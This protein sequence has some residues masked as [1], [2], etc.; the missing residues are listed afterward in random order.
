M[1][2]AVYEVPNGATAYGRAANGATP[3]LATVATATRATNTNVCN[4]TMGDNIRMCSQ[5]VGCEDVDLIRVAEDRDWC[6][7]F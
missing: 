3:A 4:K 1:E 7:L 2:W 5:G 6:G